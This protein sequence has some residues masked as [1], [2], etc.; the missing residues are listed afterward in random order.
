MEIHAGT[1]NEVRCQRLR[2]MCCA[3][4]GGHR[5]EF[6]GTLERLRTFK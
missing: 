2:N 1:Y 4:S 6:G 3:G 5:N